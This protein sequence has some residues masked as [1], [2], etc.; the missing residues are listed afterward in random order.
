MVKRRSYS[1][2]RKRTY[3]KPTPAILPLMGLAARPV[4]YLGFA[5][6][7]RA[8]DIPKIALTHYTGFQDGK[9]RPDA[10]KI[11]AATYGPILLGIAGHKIAARLGVNRML[12]RG[13]NL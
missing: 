11:L 12:P 4:E 6:N 5:M 2:K 7:G 8:A 3:R 13:I 9:L 10:G 1:R